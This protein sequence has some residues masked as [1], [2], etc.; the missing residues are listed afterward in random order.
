MLAVMTLPPGPRDSFS[1]WQDRSRSGVDFVNNLIIVLATGLIA[2]ALNQATDAAN[3]RHLDS[4]QRVC[5]GVAVIVLGISTTAGVGLAI[6][7]L[8]VTRLTARQ[9]RLREL[10]DATFRGDY[11]KRTRRDMLDD[12]VK[13]LTGDGKVHSLWRW[14]HKPIRAAAGKYPVA[15]S[16]DQPPFSGPSDSELSNEQVAAQLAVA[17]QAAADQAAANQAAAEQVNVVIGEIRELTR[18]GD[19]RTW[20]LLNAQLLSFVAGAL[21]FVVVIGSNYFSGR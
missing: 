18:S 16:G 5:E 10:R 17:Q 13:N 19:R 21:L 11:E 12:Y 20:W 4:W 14:S 15:T 8:H 9:I 1:R 2:V 6:N 7:R 3:F